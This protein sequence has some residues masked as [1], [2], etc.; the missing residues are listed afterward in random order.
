MCARNTAAK[1]QNDDLH[2]RVRKDTARQERERERRKCE[3]KKQ[4]REAIVNE[5]FFFLLK[6]MFATL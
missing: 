3:L 2:R 4:T 1:R 6:L 5:K